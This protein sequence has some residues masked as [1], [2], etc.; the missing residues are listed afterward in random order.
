MYWGR[1]FLGAKCVQGSWRALSHPSPQYLQ[2]KWP[3]LDVP[4][5]ATLKDNRSPSPAH[6]VRAAPTGGMVGSQHPR[7][8]VVR[9]FRSGLGWKDS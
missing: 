8:P 1:V 3:L 4:A 9:E 6:L 7:D 2:M 5:G